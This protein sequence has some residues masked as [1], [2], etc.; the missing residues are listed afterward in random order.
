MDITPFLDILY[1]PFG[2]TNMVLA[3]VVHVF[4]NF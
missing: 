1:L 2:F 4:L 3:S